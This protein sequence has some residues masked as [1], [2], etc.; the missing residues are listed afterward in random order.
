[1]A[2]FAVAPWQDVVAMINSGQSC[3]EAAPGI[4]SLVTPKSVGLFVTI[5]VTIV[6]AKTVAPEMMSSSRLLFSW[7]EDR[8]FPESFSKVNRFKAPSVSLVISA[9]IGSVFLIDSSLV[10]WEIGVII[11]ATTILLVVMFL[12]FGVIK[13]YFSK[14]KKDWQKSV[15]TPAMLAS[16]VAGIIVALVMIPTVLY[17]PGSPL[18]FQPWLQLLGSLAISVRIYAYAYRHWSSKGV[19]LEKELLSNLPLE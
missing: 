10:G 3:Y 14:H 4:I 16:A 5:L 2:I 6:L 1:M 15:T 7:S 11:R 18:V 12:G 19:N 8:I 17:K 9:V 13:T